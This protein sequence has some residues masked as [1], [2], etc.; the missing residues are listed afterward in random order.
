MTVYSIPN[1][2][3]IWERNGGA[4]SH[5]TVAVSVSMA[6]SGGNS[7]ARSPSNDW[8]L[9]Q[10]NA[11]N[12]GTLG[13]NEADIL[14]P[15]VNARCAIRMSGNGTNWAPWCTC[16]DNPGRDCGH[17]YLPNPQSGSPAGNQVIH[18]AAVL[19]ISGALAPSASSG[20]GNIAPVQSAW[21]G[22]NDFTGA[23]ARHNFGAINVTRSRIRG[24]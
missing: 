6:E 10:I 13:V 1:V 15:D 3:A 20:G 4:S 18:V 24:A 5:V 22:F 19:G 7:N 9:W 16:W 17:G 11:T 12:F 2:A 14:D 21:N 8:G 23:Y